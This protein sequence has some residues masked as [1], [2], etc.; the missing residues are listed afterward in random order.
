[1]YGTQGIHGIGQAA[2]LHLDRA[3]GQ[4]L[5]ALDRE[6]THAQ[7]VDWT[8]I[9]PSRAAL[10]VGLVRRGVGGHE[11]NTLQGELLECMAGDR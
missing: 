3:D 8:G 10:T 7:P 5:Y 1:M 9:H 2:A 6:L 11:Q 4:S